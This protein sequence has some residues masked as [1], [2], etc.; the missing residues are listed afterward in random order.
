VLVSAT[1]RPQTKQGKSNRERHQIFNAHHFL[2]CVIAI[3]AMLALGHSASAETVLLQEDFNAE[4]DGNVQTNYTG[5]TQF[6]V[7][8]GS[9]DL[10]G[11]FDL[12]DPGLADFFPAMGS[13]STSIGRRMQQEGSSLMLSSH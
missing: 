3:V 7:T 2:A 11:A 9:V 6:N 13:T 4:N 8:V 5:F 12:M 10:I 1:I